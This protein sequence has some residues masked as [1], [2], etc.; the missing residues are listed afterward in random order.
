MLA[1]I[2]SLFATTLFASAQEVPPY[3][4]HTYEFATPEFQQVW[5][6]TDRPV[7]EGV[8]ERTWMWGPGANTDLTQEPYAEADN[9]ERDVQYT[10]KSR[11]E[12]PVHPVD[13][14]SDWY[15]TQGLLAWE[16]MSG[17]VQVGDAE[18]VEAFPA[19]IQI[20]G[21]P[22]SQGPTYATM[23]MHL[24]SSPRTGGNLITDFMHAGGNIEPMSH[25]ETYAVTDVDGD[26]QSVEG[27]NQPIA[28]VFWGFMNSTGPVYENGNLETGPV[29]ANPIYAVGY[30]LTPAYWTWVQVNNVEQNVLIQCF[31]RRCLTYTPDN[32]Q[33]WQVESGNVGQHYFDWRY[34]Q[35]GDIS[36]PTPPVDD[37]ADDTVDD[38]ADDSVGD[39]ADDTVDDSAD[40]SAD[41]SVDDDAPTVEVSSFSVAPSLSTTL[42]NTSHTITVTVEGTDDEPFSGASVSATVTDGPHENTALTSASTVTNSAGQVSLSYTG[43][44]TGTDTITVTVAGIAGS[45]TVSKIWSEVSVSVSPDDST[46]PYFEGFEQVV[47]F[48]ALTV[49]NAAEDN[50]DISLDV[51]QFFID[52]Y[53]SFAVDPAANIDARIEMVLKEQLGEADVEDLMQ[54]IDDAGMNQHTFTV[55]I[56]VPA[57]GTSTDFDVLVE[58]EDDSEL[59][60][61]KGNEL[62]NGE[63]TKEFTY[64]AE[65][66]G[67]DSIT[68]TVEGEDFVFQDAKEWI[69]QPVSTD[70][71]LDLTPLNPDPKPVGSDHTVTGT[72][73]ESDT[74]ITGIANAAVI[75][76]VDDGPNK[77][78]T[79]AGFTDA[80]GAVDFTYTDGAEAADT[81]TITATASY[82]DDDG[83]LVEVAA[84]TSAQKEWYFAPE[85]VLIT[86]EDPYDHESHADRDG[87]DVTV[88][89]YDQN[90]QPMTDLDGQDI[91]IDLPS[92]IDGGGQMYFGGA[93]QGYAQT[94]QT[95]NGTV[96]F[97]I[98]SSREFYTRPTD[99]VINAEMPGVT[100]SE[101]SET[102]TFPGPRQFG[103]TIVKNE[104]DGARQ[105]DT[106]LELAGNIYNPDDGDDDLYAVFKTTFSHGSYDCDAGENFTDVFEFT[107]VDTTPQEDQPHREPEEYAHLMNVSFECESDSGDWVGVWGNRSTG[108]DIYPGMDQTD[109]FTMTVGEETAT[110]E[111][112]VSADMV[113]KGED[114]DDVDDREI[115]STVSQTFTILGQLGLQSNYAG[116]ATNVF[117]GA[118]GNSAWS[119]LSHV[120]EEENGEVSTAGVSSGTPT[121][122]LVLSD[123]GFD[124]PDEATIVG[125]E[126]EVW[127]SAE[128]SE[129]VS[130][131]MIHLTKNGTSGVGDNLNDDVAWPSSITSRTY[132]ADDWLW[133][134]SLGWY[135][136]DIN[137]DSFGLLIR[138]RGDNG[139]AQVDAA[140]ITVHYEN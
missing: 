25:L 14:E 17:Q 11:M 30:P 98:I 2:A 124:I 139:T 3:N 48:H 16:L 71:K 92:G 38:G 131:R 9:G 123:F 113:D 60:D 110:G 20:A 122:I 115:Y 22:N 33:A 31:E 69:E 10:D 75:F 100:G 121:Q 130:D 78:L 42:V 23:G 93:D 84:T 26:W 109:T 116:G 99:V 32:T 97:T 89:M 106:G 127:R 61:S 80:D 67:F 140:Q 46:N 58:H 13:L 56:S 101:D 96:E 65:G 76:E 1:L 36:D 27:I 103:L 41:D 85:Y 24:D 62:T 19:E 138:A 55:D 57:G 12:M 107:E 104:L 129:P 72:L 118:G 29:V 105:G 114:G 70:N 95:T 87:I 37:G 51:D 74:S 79:G 73:T 126:V 86:S 111:W 21:D 134:T 83:N 39:G 117:S 91:D 68:V 81:D 137:A 66:V 102:I 120:V 77:G 34:N 90:D 40:D 49:F 128:G 28:N 64:S 82:L 45:Q 4:P 88:T 125:I 43:T 44:D 54:V 50:A 35:V 135:P 59:L 136:S 7:Q 132:G 112:T 53:Q 8:A 108:E 18:F 15:I 6:R 47:M 94:L 5:D 119:S 63:A 52:F 133:N